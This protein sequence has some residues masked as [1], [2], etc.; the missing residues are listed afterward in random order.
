[1]L[2]NKVN[3]TSFKATRRRLSEHPIEEVGAKLRA[4]MPW[5]RANRLV[6]QSKN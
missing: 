1:M 4:M 5:I 6:D 2:E 3:Q